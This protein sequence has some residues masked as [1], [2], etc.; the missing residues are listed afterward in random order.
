MGI[1]KIN[2]KTSL[3]IS[4]SPI[5]PIEQMQLTLRGNQFLGHDFGAKELGHEHGIVYL[6][7]IL[8]ENYGQLVQRV[9]IQLLLGQAEAG[10]AVL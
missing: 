8:S 2:E 1:N 9:F 5:E 6:G 4:F 10:A 3:K 7:R